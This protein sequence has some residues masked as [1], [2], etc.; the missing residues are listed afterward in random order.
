M[1]ILEYTQVSPTAAT[2][3]PSL[4]RLDISSCNKLRGWELIEDKHQFLRHSKLMIYECPNLT[5]LPTFPPI[6]ELELC[7]S[8]LKPLNNPPYNSETFK[9]THSVDRP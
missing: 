9:H 6:E 3:F 2:F 1:R 8:T 4:E 7:K 5:C